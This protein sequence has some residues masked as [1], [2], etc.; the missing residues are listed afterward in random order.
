MVPC[1][2][3]CS[4]VPLLLIM[5]FLPSVREGRQTQFCGRFP[6]IFTW[7]AVLAQLEMARN[8]NRASPPGGAA[9]APEANTSPSEA[10]AIH[11]TL[12][13]LQDVLERCYAAWGRAWPPPCP[14]PMAT[15]PPEGHSTHVRL[16]C[17]TGGTDSFSDPF[18]S[19]PLPDGG[20]V[21]ADYGHDAI[22]IVSPTGQVVRT[23]GQRGRSL[24][25]LLRPRGLALTDDGLYVTDDADRVQVFDLDGR[26]TWSFP[27]R[28]LGAPAVLCRPHGLARARNGLVYVADTGHHRVAAFSPEGALSFAFGH[29]GAEPGAF[30][31]PRGLTVAGERVWVA[32]MCNHRVQAF[33]LDGRLLRVIGRHGH[34]PS[35][36]T[37]PVGVGISG[38]RPNPSPSPSPNPSPSPHPHPSP[39]PNL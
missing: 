4:E 15:D 26:A 16:I 13:P 25:Q 24:G 31:E 34:G 30:D 35:Q 14:P 1:V 38:E 2:G 3:V 19:V 39:N 23:L 20:Y 29:A 11:Q 21:V 32:D 22:S 36:F 27:A 33:D 8:P 9:A 10:A 17:S 37:H 6:E 28:A 12:V 7:R 18:A 5:R